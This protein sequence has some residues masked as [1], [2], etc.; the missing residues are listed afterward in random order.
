VGK[1]RRG[2]YTLLITSRHGHRVKVIYRLVF[3]VR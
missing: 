1:L 3:L 2:R